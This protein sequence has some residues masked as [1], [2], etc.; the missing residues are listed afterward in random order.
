[1]QMMMQIFQRNYPELVEGGSVK[2]PIED[3]L[4]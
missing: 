4:I 3:K 2:Y 1:M